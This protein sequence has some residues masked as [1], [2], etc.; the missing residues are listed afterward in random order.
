[1]LR[2]LYRWLLRLHPPGFRRRFGDEMLL[3]FDQ[4]VGK[5]AA[6]KLLGDGML[7]LARQ[8]GLR[9]EFWHG[10]SPAPTPQPASDGIPSFAILDPFRPRTAA[11]IHGLVLSTAVFC[12]TCFA[13]RYSWIHV[14]HVHIP[15]VQFESPSVMEPSTNAPA[16]PEEPAVPSRQEGRAKN[17]IPGPFGAEPGAEDKASGQPPV[18]PVPQNKTLGITPAPPGRA[19]VAPAVQPRS[20]LGLAAN[21]LAATSMPQRRPTQLLAE[22]DSSE[23]QKDSMFSHQISRTTIET[24]SQPQTYEGTYV[25]ESPE[26]FTISITTEDGHLVMNVAGQPKRALAPVSETKFVV[27]G[28][29]NCW[30][31]F[32]RDWGTDADATI[33]QLRLFQNGQQFIARRR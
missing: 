27:K 23:A 6:L 16:M 2:S 3:I 9:S 18:S 15:E 11:V 26:R 22:A 13:I 32:V 31:E 1:M 30:I 21:P 28:I 7:S 33:R 17:D 19:Q 29:E 5:A 24:Q 4:A 25:V 20:P 10:I 14:L 12:L 8:W